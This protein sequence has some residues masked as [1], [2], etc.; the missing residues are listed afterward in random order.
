MPLVEKLLRASGLDQNQDV[1]IPAAA[2]LGGA[3]VALATDRP[4][5]KLV[6]MIM[7]L[8]NKRDPISQEQSRQVIRR[9]L[10]GTAFKSAPGSA[11]FTLAGDKAI[12]HDKKVHR[13]STMLHEA[14][15]LSDRGGKVPNKLYQLSKRMYPLGAISAAG[16]GGYEAGEGEAKISPYAA[17][18]A[19]LIGAPHL[20][21]EGRASMNAHHFASKAK[22]PRPNGALRALGSYVAKPSMLAGA[23]TA[24]GLGYG[25]SKL[26]DN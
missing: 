5:S 7:A 12:Y 1:T 11:A 17:L 21:E 15:H 6:D 14:G 18:A 20:Y 2:G 13:G 24:A 4:A 22:L 10:P 19:A 3:G 16:F 25:A 9:E 26:T 23:L 8:A